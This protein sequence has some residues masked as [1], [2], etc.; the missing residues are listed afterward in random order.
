ML[1][2]GVAASVQGSKRLNEA[3]G[4]QEPQVDPN[5]NTARQ[6]ELNQG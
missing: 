3:G 4:C 5:E 1:L 6:V 2:S